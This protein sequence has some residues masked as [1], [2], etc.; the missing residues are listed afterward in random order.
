MDE[1][2]LNDLK[3]NQAKIAGAQNAFATGDFKSG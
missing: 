1:E 2:S 3:E